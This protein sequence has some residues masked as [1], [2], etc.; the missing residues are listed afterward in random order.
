MHNKNK[1][2]EDAAV[3]I[4]E[5]AISLVYFS[6]VTPVMVC[7]LSNSVCCC[8]ISIS[9]NYGYTL[10]WVCI[11]VILTKIAVNYLCWFNWEEK[12]HYNK[13]VHKL[14]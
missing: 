9:Y 14:I 7:V 8:N 6:R 12:I 1:N 3:T 11:V 13:S 5:R 4:A 2:N 10:T